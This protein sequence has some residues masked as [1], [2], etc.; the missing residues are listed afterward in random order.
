MYK[1]LSNDGKYFTSTLKSFYTN[2]FFYLIE[3]YFKYN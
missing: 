1:N 3:E 2:I